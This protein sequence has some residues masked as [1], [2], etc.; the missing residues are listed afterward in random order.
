MDEKTIE[1][2]CRHDFV[3]ISE[4]E[5][6]RIY[7][8]LKPSYL[9]EKSNIIYETFTLNYGRHGIP[10]IVRRAENIP[11]GMIPVGFV[12]L[13]RFEGNRLRIAT[14]TYVRETDEVITPFQV[15]K[16]III[17]RN[18][19]LKAALEIAKLAK[20]LDVS[21]GIVGSAGIEI[22]TGLPYT[23]GASDLD[24]LITNCDSKRLTM[25]YEQIKIIG[26]RHQTLIDL[27]VVLANGYGIKAIELFMDTQTLLGKSLTTVELLS[28]ED[29]LKIMERG[30]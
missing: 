18:N 4:Q 26:E 30:D 7:E 8:T 19:C 12:P 1:P 15:F 24:L 14:F 5:R 9:G 21:L 27:E 25:V 22:M 17:P 6:K 29:V 3:L 20:K 23:D 16:M 11:Q 2:W 10:G 28:R 13:A